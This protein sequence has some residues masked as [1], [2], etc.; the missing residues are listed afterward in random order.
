MCKRL[1]IGTAIVALLAARPA[2]IAQNVIKRGENL[3]EITVVGAG[4]DKD[5]AVRDALRKAV[6]RGAGAIIHSE[7]QTRDFALVRDTVLVRATGFI[8]SH[9]ILSQRQVEDGTWE[10]KVTAVV[11]VKGIVDYWGVVKT[12]LK[13]MGRPKIMVFIGERIRREVVPDST[14]QARIENLL[15]KSGFLLVNKQQLKAIDRKDLAAA[16]AEDKPAKAQAI[17]K[18][19]G[20]QLFI[21]GTANAASGGRKTIGGVVFETYEAE[22]NVKCYRSDTGQLLS[23]IP[24]RPTRGV[25]RVWRSA[26]KNALDAQARQI[27]PRVQNDVL[28]FWQDALAGRGEVQLHVE[29]LSFTQYTALK[30][31]LKTI[32]QVKDVTTPKYHNKVAECS[33]ESDVNAETLAEKIVE[34]IKNLEITDV[35]QNVIKAK[36]QQE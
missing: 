16:V 36:L 21:S 13:Q 23:S 1:L 20:A 7:S 28:R 4:M 8:Q 5:E 29:G 2:A 33:L 17:A 18:R 12:K 35:S 22:A 24:G 9:K 11:S 26:A 14:V 10:A 3:V 30:K 25:N 34:V 32:K 19:F 27:A 31:A 6:E 15:L